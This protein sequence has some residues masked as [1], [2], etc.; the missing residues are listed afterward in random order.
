MIDFTNIEFYSTP[1]GEVMI[2]PISGPVKILQE[3]D[4][5]L[6]QGMLQLINDRYPDA[7][8]ALSDLYSRSTMNRSYYEFAMVHRFCRCNFGAFDTMQLDVDKQG[9]LHLEQVPCP[10]RNTGDCKL[11]GV[12]CSPRLNT[13]LTAR[14]MDIL[15]LIAAGYTNKQIANE[16]HISIFTVIRHRNNMRAKLG[17]S[18]TA[19]LVSCY[20][21]MQHG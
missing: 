5:E 3:S 19:E 6:I 4:R 20:K 14:E 9:N 18:N 12:V 10:L 17:V 8:A 21:N 15:E 16:I 11:C 7:F 13:K 1:E 2:K